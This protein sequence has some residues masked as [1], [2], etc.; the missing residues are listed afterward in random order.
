MGVQEGKDIY[1]SILIHVAVWQKPSQYCRVLIL[2]LKMLK[3][4]KR[5]LFFLNFILFLNFT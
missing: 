5:F 3:R 2:Q 1:M 4:K